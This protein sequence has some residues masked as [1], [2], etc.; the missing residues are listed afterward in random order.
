MTSIL[1]TRQ[2]SIIEWGEH[3]GDL[4]VA[5]K[6]QSTRRQ[7]RQWGPSCKLDTGFQKP[8]TALVAHCRLASRFRLVI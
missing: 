7:Q 8:R 3:R 2:T 6:V 5:Y 1:L 4:F